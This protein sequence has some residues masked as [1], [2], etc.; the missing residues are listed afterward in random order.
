[1]PIASLPLPA[2]VLSVHDR[3]TVVRDDLLPGGTKRRA[4]HVFFDDEHTEYVY[5]SPVQGAA[6]LALAFTARE[7]GKRVRIFCA[8]RKA[9]HANT[10]RVAELG[11]IIE[12]VPMGFLSNVTAKAQTYCAHSGA[13]MLPFGLD[14]PE[15]IVALA[16]VARTIDYQPQEVWSIASSGVLSRALQLAWPDAR[17]FG[18]RVGHPPVASKATIYTAAEKFERDAKF[19]PPFPSCGNYDAKAWNLIKQHASRTERVLF[20]NVSA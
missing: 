7:F 8:E 5:A 20:W 4:I 16:G 10:S 6:Q 15:F 12:E 18:V 3:V 2:P 17:F 11:G 13:K 14:A 19:P 9:W 1:M